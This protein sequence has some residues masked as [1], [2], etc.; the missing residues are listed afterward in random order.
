MQ[1]YRN[2]YDPFIPILILSVYAINHPGLVN[3]AVSSAPG[4]IHKSPHTDADLVAARQGVQSVACSNF[5]GTGSGAE[6]GVA[7]ISHLQT[8]PPSPEWAPPGLPKF[9]GLNSLTGVAGVWKVNY[10]FWGIKHSTHSS[11]QLRTSD[12]MYLS[13]LLR[14]YWLMAYYVSIC[15]PPPPFLK[16]S[17]PI[18]GFASNF[19]KIQNDRTKVFAQLPT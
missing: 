4:N 6:I 13:C 9:V 11:Y 19:V 1:R 10:N 7:W 2:L 18:D 16:I 14:K 8:T 5:P 3:R 15:L 12:L 17:K